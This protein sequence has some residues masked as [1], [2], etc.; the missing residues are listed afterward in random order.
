MRND[1]LRHH[2]I[3]G[4][5]W[6]IRRYQNKDGSLTAAGRKRYYNEDGSLT[7]KGRKRDKKDQEW[8]NS[9]KGIAV[10]AAGLNAVR[11]AYKYDAR[12]QDAVDYL[13]QDPKYRNEACDTEALWRLTDVMD[14]AVADIRTPSG[15]AVH[16]A[17]L[18]SG[19][20]LAAIDEY[21]EFGD[22]RWIY[23]DTVLSMVLR[24]EK[25]QN[26]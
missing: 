23:D 10:A 22:P 3:L 14:T 5:K 9:D 6:G 26:K 18:Q 13:S 16:F 17:T 20:V 21:S 2:G 1:E 25:A 4:M 11:N 19:V 15:R 24:K 8:A 7:E 12:I